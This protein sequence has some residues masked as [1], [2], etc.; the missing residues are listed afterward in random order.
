MALEYLESV[1]NWSPKIDKLSESLNSEKTLPGKS[2]LKSHDFMMTINN[3]K[4]GT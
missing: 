2:V 3:L 1:T 4:K